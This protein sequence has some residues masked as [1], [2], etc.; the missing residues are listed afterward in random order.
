MAGFSNIHASLL[1]CMG[2][3]DESKFVVQALE[4]AV[5]AA[6]GTATVIMIDEW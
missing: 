4:L 2:G 3:W 1:C 5:Q 6:G